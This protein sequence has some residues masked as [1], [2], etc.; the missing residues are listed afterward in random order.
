MHNPPKF[1]LHNGVTQNESR[2]FP[3]NFTC[4]KST[5][6]CDVRLDTNLME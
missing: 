4:K 3:L 6:D 1:A 5:F 2:P